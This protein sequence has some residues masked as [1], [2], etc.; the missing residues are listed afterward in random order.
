MARVVVIFAI[1][2][3]ITVAMFWLAQHPNTHSDVLA[4]IPVAPGDKP[5]TTPASETPP[6]DTATATSPTPPASGSDALPPAEAATTA[7]VP[8]LPSTGPGAD[9]L[10]Q[11][12]T[13]SPNTAQTGL[14]VEDVAAGGGNSIAL[15]GRA[16]PGATVR[17]SV[18]GKP[19]GEVTV[20]GGGSWSLAVDKG[21]G[22]A[23]P[24]IVL[25]LVAADGKVIDKTNFVFKTLTAPPLSPQDHTLITAQTATPKET[26]HKPH[27][28]RHGATFRVRRGESLWRIARRQLGSGDK[29]RVLYEANKERIGGDPDYIKPGTRLILPS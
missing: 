10:Q 6:A 12:T 9:V 25:E 18:N 29:W 17:V 20:G 27:R 7:S 14:V 5:S 21:K 24:T 19:A 4:T 11:T 13:T 26:V 16:D 15:K 8:P 22:E 23:E 1:L 2:S 3:L 28:Q